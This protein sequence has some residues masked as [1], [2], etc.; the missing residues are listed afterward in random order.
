[1]KTA[2]SA[3]PQWSRFHLD[4]CPDGSLNKRDLFFMEAIKPEIKTN[5]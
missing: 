5:E 3:I 4:T 1:V 2:Y